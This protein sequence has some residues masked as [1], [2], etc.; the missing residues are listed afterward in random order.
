[1]AGRPVVARP[2]GA[3]GAVSSSSLERLHRHGFPLLAHT[4]RRPPEFV[5]GIKLMVEIFDHWQDAGLTVGERSD[6]LVLAENA[7]DGTRQTFGPVHA[8]YILRRAG[9]TLGAW[10]STS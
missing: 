2:S 6:L 10:R 7:N 5:M 1:M 3:L 8:E 4:R 9:T